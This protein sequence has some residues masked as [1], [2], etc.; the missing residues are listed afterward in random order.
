MKGKKSDPEFLSQFIE[1][2]IWQNINTPE[3]MVGVAQAEIEEINHKI[4]EVEELKVKRSK[5]LD[6]VANFQKPNKSKLQEA[7][8]ISF[9]QIQYPDICFYI[10][11][12]M[13]KCN[14]TL[15]ELYNP[16]FNLSDTNFCIKQLLEHQVIIKVG[17][18]FL[19]GEAF[20]KY[21]KFILREV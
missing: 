1:R 4:L 11:E 19:R 20:E 13:K 10:C 15:Q 5:L 12:L 9:F 6:V 18:S 3:E 8:L 16:K 21:L 7:E 2:C 17:N 14:C